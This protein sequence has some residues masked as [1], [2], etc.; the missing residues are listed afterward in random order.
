MNELL[1]FESPD[2]SS[3]FLYD[4]YGNLI[5]KDTNET[6]WDYTYD[7]ENRLVSAKKSHC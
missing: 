1:S 3:T 2:K 6:L 4:I 5:Q 7:Y